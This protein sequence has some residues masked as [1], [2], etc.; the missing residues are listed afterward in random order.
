[1]VNHGR[2]IRKVAVIGAGAA[3]LTALKAMREE[4]L[5]TVAFE[6]SPEVGGV[7][8]YDEAAP[9]GGGPA[10]RSLTTNT[11]ARMLA[12]SDFPMPH[13]LPDFPARSDVLQYLNDYADNFDLRSCIQFNTRIEKVEPTDDN[14]WAVHV[15]SGSGLQQIFDAVVVAS[16]FYRDPRWTVLPGLDTFQGHVL[17][18]SA[19]QGPELFAGQRVVVIGAGSSGSDIAAEISQTAA[20]VELA[21]RSG[22]WFTPHFQRGRPSDYS[23]T[24]LSQLVPQRIKT[25]FMRQSLLKIYQEHGLKIETL[26]LPPFDLARSRLSSGTRIFTQLRSGAVRLK[27]GVT[28]IEADGVVYADGTRSPADW[29]VMATG[30]SV[31]FPF[32]PEGTIRAAELYRHVFPADCANLACIGMNMVT[33]AVYPVSEMQARWAARVFSGE[34]TLPT[35]DARRRAIQAHVRL[36]QQRGTKLTRVDRVAY[37]DELAGL[38]GVRPK[39]WR[40]LK[41]LRVLLMEPLAAAQYRL[42]GPGKNDRAED[43]LTGR[44][45]R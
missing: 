9:G 31:S 7:W 18:S 22:V 36:H 5:D 30:Y 45:K 44:W 40:H 43:I 41:L 23:L 8:K 27:P 33:G 13:G 16:G 21:A 42:D 12:F 39:W 19:Y 11:S 4:G 2:S 3:G 26:A 10:Y 32:L 34:C 14:R 24:R 38:I 37:L 28:G 17:H 25:S 35:P 1:M 29:L 6:Q 15:Q 20:Q